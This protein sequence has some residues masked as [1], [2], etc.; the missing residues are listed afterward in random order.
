MLGCIPTAPQRTRVSLLHSPSGSTEACDDALNAA[1]LKRYMIKCDVVA[2]APG[3]LAGRCAVESHQ[4]FNSQQHRLSG[5]CAHTSDRPAQQAPAAPTRPLALVPLRQELMAQFKL[6]RRRRS[7]ARRSNAQSTRKAC[8]AMCHRRSG[9]DQRCCVG[10]HR[11]I[12][13][14]DLTV[15]GPHQ[16]DGLWGANPCT[17]RVACWPKPMVLRRASGAC[18]QAGVRGA[19]D[20]AAQHTLRKAEG[21]MR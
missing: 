20:G 14:D 15:A 1:P 6:R 17:A 18:T 7:N 4:S 8:S 3:G 10:R 21:E 19:I 2:G 9:G 11:P 16:A 12:V 13:G 5:T